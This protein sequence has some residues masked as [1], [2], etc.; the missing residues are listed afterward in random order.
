MGQITN[1]GLALPHDVLWNHC[2][3]RRVQVTRQVTGA[4]HRPQRGIRARSGTSSKGAAYRLAT[5][6]Q[7]PAGSDLEPA[8]LETAG[9]VPR[10]LASKPVISRPDE[11]SW[12][13]DGNEQDFGEEKNPPKPHANP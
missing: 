5:A 12:D 11:E 6:R 2:R 8:R 9:G 13:F 4:L 1:V 3:D 10:D 7:V